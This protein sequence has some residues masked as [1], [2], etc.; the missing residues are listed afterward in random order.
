MSVFITPGNYIDRPSGTDR[1][2]LQFTAVRLAKA[3]AAA[4]HRY[5]DLVFFISSYA[6]VADNERRGLFSRIDFR[7]DVHCI[8][9]QWCFR[10]SH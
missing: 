5:M 4:A 6:I 9:L 2:F 7:S 1:G 10:A 3:T 8:N